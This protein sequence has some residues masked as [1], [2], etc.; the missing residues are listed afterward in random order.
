MP[1]SRSWTLAGVT[2]ACNSRPCMSTRTWRFFP[3]INLPAS[4]P[5]GSMR[6]PFF[7]ALDALAV[8]DTGG[9][10]GFQVKLFAAFDV[11]GVMD[12]IERAIPAPIA[13]IAKHCTLGRQILGDIAPLASRAQHI[14]HAF[15]Q[16][17]LTPLASAPATARP[18]NKRRNLR[19]LRVR[20]IARI[21]QMIA[22][23]SGAICVRPHRQ[24]LESGCRRRNHN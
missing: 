3:L 4:K 12:P 19:P 8:D 6:A 7:C 1:P 16:L 18:R 20:Q 9:W 23:I 14:H 11:Q 2:S 5:G 21:S 24:L 13:E 22:I 17:T 10:T 15:H